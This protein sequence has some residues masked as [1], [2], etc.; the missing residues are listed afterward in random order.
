MS[1]YYGS[2]RGVVTLLVRT[3]PLLMLYITL[4]IGGWH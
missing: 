1:S 4:Y 3:G 2:P